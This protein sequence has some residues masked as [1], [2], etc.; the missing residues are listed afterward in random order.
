MPVIGEG[1]PLFGTRVPQVVHRSSDATRLAAKDAHRLHERYVLLSPTDEAF[2]ESA[3]HVLHLTRDDDHRRLMFIRVESDA[4][5]PRIF[6][7]SQRTVRHVRS[8]STELRVWQYD[9]LELFR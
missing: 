1:V 6:V 9:N 5:V 3:N 4:L 7:A 2:I 8:E